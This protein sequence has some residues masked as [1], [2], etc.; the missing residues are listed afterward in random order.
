VLRALGRSD[1]LAQSSIRFSLGRFTTDEEI[2]AAIAAVNQEVP[3]LRALA[4][5]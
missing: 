4:L 2:E 3:R 1:Q 5:S